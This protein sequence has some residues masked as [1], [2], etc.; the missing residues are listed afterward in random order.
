[1]GPHGDSEYSTHGEI[2]QRPDDPG[3]RERDLESPA[4]A[5]G[6]AKGV[7]RATCPRDSISCYCWRR[8]VARA[9]VLYASTRLLRPRVRARVERVRGGVTAEARR[10]ESP[11]SRGR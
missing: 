1:M 2:L 7:A 9:T 4:G 11:P 5:G 6:V 8:Q 10:L 3:V